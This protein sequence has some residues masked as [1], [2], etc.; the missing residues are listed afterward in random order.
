MWKTGRLYSAASQ[1]KIL[2]L[3]QRVAYHY[4][5]SPSKAIMSDPSPTILNTIWQHIPTIVVASFYPQWRM[6]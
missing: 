2:L 6:C 1:Y 4:M 5:S 3:Q